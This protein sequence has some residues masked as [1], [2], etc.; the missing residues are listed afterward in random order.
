M[1]T[2]D[3]KQQK[4]KVKDLLQLAKLEALFILS[5]DDH[6]YIVEQADEFEQEVKLLGENQKFMSFLSKRSAE[7]AFTSI[8]ELEKKLE[9]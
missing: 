8:D 2:I 4:P 1:E 5:E 7:Q 3:L 9:L 6:Q